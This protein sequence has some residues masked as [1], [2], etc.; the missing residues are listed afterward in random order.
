MR[1]H[2]VLDEALVERAKRLT[3]I[4]TTRGVVEQALEQHLGLA[5][6]HP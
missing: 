5:V 2:I 6:I 1:T 4:R 3:G